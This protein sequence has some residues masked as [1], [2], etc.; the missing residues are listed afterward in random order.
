MATQ[1][2]LSMVKLYKMSRSL[3]TQVLVAYDDSLELVLPLQSATTALTTIWKD[4][5]VSKETKIGLLYSL[6]F[7]IA[8]Y[9]CETWVLQSFEIWSYRLRGV[10]R[11]PV[12]WTERITYDQ[13]LLTE[14]FKR[15]FLSS[16]VH[17]CLSYLGNI[18]RSNILE[19]NYCWDVGLEQ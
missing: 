14:Q 10:L 11:I 4:R 6:V 19:K 12:S 18:L 7:P 13:V 2:I 8:S 17:G 15:Q 9:G 1:R 16:L 3:H 5:S